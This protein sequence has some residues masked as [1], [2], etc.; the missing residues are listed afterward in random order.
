[1]LLQDG[2][3]SVVGYVLNSYKI[4]ISARNSGRVQPRVRGV[5]CCSYN[6]RAVWTHRNRNLLL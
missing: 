6:G 5:F 3:V 2:L 4:K 1:M